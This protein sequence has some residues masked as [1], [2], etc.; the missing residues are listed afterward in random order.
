MPGP[1]LRKIAIFSLKTFGLRFCLKSSHRLI[2]GLLS[3]WCSFRFLRLSVAEK[4]H[5]QVFRVF[6]FLT[7]PRLGKIAIFSEKTFGLRFWLKSSHRL[8]L[9]PLSM[10]WSL[11][12][13]RLSVAEKT[14]SQVF[15]VLQVLP[16]PR[17]VKIAIFSLK[18]FG[19]WFYLKS[20]HRLI[21]RSEERRVGKECRSRWS[22]YH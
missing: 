13:L 4:K 22:P 19:L 17:L 21:L 6:H 2:L 11:T 3:M 18:T 20:S 14:H 10:W 1:R 12:F 8:I 9:G 16:G 15:R 7:A 5:N